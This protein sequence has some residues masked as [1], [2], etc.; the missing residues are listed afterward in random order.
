MR[1]L[2]SEQI[3]IDSIPEWTYD[4]YLV[5]SPGRAQS[6]WELLAKQPQ[7]NI[8]AWY[9]DLH[10]LS[11]A[12]RT[13]NEGGH[14]LQFQCSSDLPEET[15]GAVLMPILKRG[16]AELTRELMQQAHQRLM[17]GGHLAVAVDNPRDT[18]VH[19]QMQVLFDKVTTRQHEQGRAYWGKKTG[20]LKRVRDFTCQ[21]EFKHDDHVI[22]AISRPGVFAH[23]KLDEGARQLLKCAEIAPTDNV[24]DFGCGCGAVALACATQTSGRVFGVDASARAVEC[25]QR[26]ATL[27]NLS[28]IQAT[29]NASGKLGLPVAIDVALTNPPYFG[30]EKIWQH[31]ADACLSVLRGG[32]SLLI[33]TKQPNWFADYLDP[34]L[35]SMSVAKAGNYFIVHGWAP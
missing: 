3:L 8:Q 1:P 26:G 23:R 18:W 28:N 35:D 30:D 17:T 9:C 21:F 32:G 22:K 29:W 15:Y 11:E 10:E 16:E 20:P 7:A 34:K 33:V 27:N 25:L 12:E 31:F 24:L 13:A 14:A 6:G 2:L 19:E 5:I 4:K